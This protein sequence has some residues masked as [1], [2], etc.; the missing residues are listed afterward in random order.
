MARAVSVGA[1]GWP[2]EPFLQASP[3]GARA[4]RLSGR[5]YVARAT[6]RPSFMKAHADQM[7]HFAAADWATSAP[8]ADSRDTTFRGNLSSVAKGLFA[9]PDAACQAAAR[10]RS[11]RFAQL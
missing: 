8:K 9:L 4:A 5:D 11:D 1:C 7:M 10:Q 3:I 2:L 6:A